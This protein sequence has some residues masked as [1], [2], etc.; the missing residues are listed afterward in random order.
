V[1]HLERDGRGIA[2][3]AGVE[4]AGGV[5]AAGGAVEL[6][7]GVAKEGDREMILDFRTPETR[8]PEPTGR[9]AKARRIESLQRHDF[10][11]MAMRSRVYWP[12]PERSFKPP[13]E[14]ATEGLVR[15]LLRRRALPIG[16][17]NFKA[18][19]RPPG[20]HRRVDGVE[21][22]VPHIPGFGTNWR[23]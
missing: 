6:A 1:H 19:R 18:P 22:Y 16:L 12:W 17:L 10:E 5:A 2:G 20:R 23:T 13:P 11:K 21:V 9:A 15:Y 7:A 14:P 8:T 3:A 4:P